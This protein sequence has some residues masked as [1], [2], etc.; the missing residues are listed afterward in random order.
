MTFDW[1][2][3]EIAKGVRG[4]LEEY[5]KRAVGDGETISIEELFDWFE[6]AVRGIPDENADVRDDLFLVATKMRYNMIVRRDNAAKDSTYEEVPV[7]YPMSNVHMG[8]FN[9]NAPYTRP[10]DFKTD[11]YDDEQ[12]FFTTDPPKESVNETAGDTTETQ[13]G[14]DYDKEARDLISKAA[15]GRDVSQLNDKEFGKL[16]RTMS[17]QAHPDMGGDSEVF[18]AVT[19][20]LDKTR[21]KRN[22]GL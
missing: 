9:F 16:K 21:E 11:A 10:T 8:G 15:D 3:Q 19:E 5:L 7:Y 14:R 2:E 18:K 12:K 20:Q 13:G 17:R 4:T 22:Q 6:A 1:Y